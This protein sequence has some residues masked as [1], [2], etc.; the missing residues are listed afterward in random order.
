ML[1]TCLVSAS[2]QIDEFLPRLTGLPFAITHAGYC[3]EPVDGEEGPLTSVRAEGNLTF[4]DSSSKATFTQLP[5]DQSASDIPSVVQ[6]YRQ[7]VKI[8]AVVLAL[9]SIQPTS[10]PA[11]TPATPTPAAQEPHLVVTLTLETKKPG[12]DDFTQLS[13]GS[14]STAKVRPGKKNTKTRD[15]RAYTA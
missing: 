6:I 10:S 3:L 15:Q 5:I 12:D 2:P 13:D 9:A 8:K 11:E 14:A 1:A 4:E 7:P